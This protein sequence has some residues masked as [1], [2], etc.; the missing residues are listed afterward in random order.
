M[1]VE[2][3]C[4]GKLA[5]GSLTWDEDGN[6]SIA[7][8]FKTSVGN[9]RI[10]IKTTGVGPQIIAYDKSDVMILKIDA[11]IDQ[12]GGTAP[13]VNLY[14]PNDSRNKVSHTIRQSNWSRYINGTVKQTVIEA[15]RLYMIDG[16][17]VVYDINKQ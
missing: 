5:D 4:S 17:T 7:G 6:L 9:E 15:G 12:Y 8:L 11:Y 3:N 14:D 1:K 2:G 16:F 10:E 13:H